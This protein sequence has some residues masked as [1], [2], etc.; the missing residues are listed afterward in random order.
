M[1]VLGEKLNIGE[2]VWQGFN[3]CSSFGSWLTSLTP[4]E[5]LCVF[6][7][8]LAALIIDVHHPSLCSFPLPQ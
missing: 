7:Y 5:E 4:Q 2:R 8:L 3:N 6:V 1:P